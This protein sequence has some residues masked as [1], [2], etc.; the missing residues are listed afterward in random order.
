LPAD[1]PPADELLRIITAARE[2][3][4]LDDDARRRRPCS[5]ASLFG[6]SAAASTLRQADTSGDHKS[7]N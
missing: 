3:G 1:A 6:D 5:T 4:K 2:A 7:A